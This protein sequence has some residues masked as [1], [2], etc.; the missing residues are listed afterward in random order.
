[1]IKK[2]GN[3]YVVAFPQRA[4]G[5]E[6][7]RVAKPSHIAGTLCTIVPK[8]FKNLVKKLVDNLMIFMQK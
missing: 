1:M 2:T 6:N 4:A 5:Q 7:K 8:I 3:K